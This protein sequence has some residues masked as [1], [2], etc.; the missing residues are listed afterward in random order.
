[1]ATYLVSRLQGQGTALIAEALDRTGFWRGIEADPFRRPEWIEAVGRAPG[2]KPDRFPIL[3]TRSCVVEVAD[4]IDHD[5]RL[6][7][8]FVD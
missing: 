8:C 3:S 7:R 2:M 4:L 1:V 6:R 5:P